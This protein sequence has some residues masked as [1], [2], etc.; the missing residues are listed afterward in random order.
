MPNSIAFARNYTSV[1]D[2]SSVK[3]T[4]LWR[5]CSEKAAQPLVFNGS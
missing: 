1:I 5:V 4:R 3:Q 2:A